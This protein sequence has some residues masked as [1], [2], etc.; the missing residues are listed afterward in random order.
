MLNGLGNTKYEE[1]FVLYGDVHIRFN[2]AGIDVYE[3]LVGEF[4]TS[5]DMAG[6]SLTLM[7]LDSELLALHDAPAATPAFSRS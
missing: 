4:V 3:P 5:L 2:E 7:W 6:C 1:L